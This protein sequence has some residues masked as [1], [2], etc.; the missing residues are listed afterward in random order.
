MTAEKYHQILIHQILINY[1]IPSGKH[2]IMLYRTV[3]A[4]EAYL[5]RK[6]QHGTLSVMES[7]PQNPDL[8]ITETVWDHLD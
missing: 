1:L 6:I 4:V 8:D 2:L 7:L 5:D 3:N